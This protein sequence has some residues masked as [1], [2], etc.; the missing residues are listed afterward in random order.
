LIDSKRRRFALYWQSKAKKVASE[1]EK[2]Q[3]G[4]RNPN[5]PFYNNNY[6]KGIIQ[7][8]ENFG[9]NSEDGDNGSPLESENGPE[10]CVPGPIEKRFL[11]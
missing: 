2:R 3:P 10:T 9:A 1:K 4:C 8:K 6:T 5:V 11:F 7:V